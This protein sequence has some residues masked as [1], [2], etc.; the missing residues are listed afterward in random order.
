MKPIRRF[1]MQ[2]Q[3]GAPRFMLSI[4]VNRAALLDNGNAGTRGQFSDS[5]W[6][7]DVFVLHHEAK[8]ASADAAAETVKGL[9]LW[10]DVERGRL[11]LM[12]WTECLEI[13]AGAFK[14]K[15]GTDHLHDVVGGCD[16]FYGF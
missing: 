4:F 11:F 9:A 14:R 7:V 8:N 5:G 10:T 12:K 2:L 1:G 16:L 3:Q 6:E 13:R 15:I